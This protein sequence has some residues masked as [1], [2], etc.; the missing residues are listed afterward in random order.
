MKR[1]VK[2]SRIAALLV[3]CAAFLCA[4][5]LAAEEEPAPSPVPEEEPFV[6]EPA[7]L[8]PYG[9]DTANRSAFG[10]ADARDGVIYFQNYPY[11]TLCAI[12]AQGEIQVL[13]E[14]CHGMINASDDA[15][16]YIGDEE[17]GIFR[18]DYETGAVA[19]LWDGT[20]DNMVTT[21]NYVFFFAENTLY[22]MEK[23][24]SNRIPVMEDLRW[25]YL[26]VV[27][28]TVYVSRRIDDDPYCANAYS[29][30][31]IDV[32]VPDAIT[33]AKEAM[34]SPVQHLGDRILC[35]NLNGLYLLEA[36]GDGRTVVLEED[37]V[38]NVR[39]AAN[40]NAVFC[41]WLLEDNYTQMRI[42]DIGTGRMSEPFP[43][44]NAA[45]Y[46]MDSKAYTVNTGDRFQ[47]EQVVPEPGYQHTEWLVGEGYRGAA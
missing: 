24:G 43:V 14:D 45:I 22:R 10:M 38:S 16:Y 36:E 20:A 41:V 25:S 31:A 23:D 18:F 5:N 40:G 33:V 44:H 11:E 37:D 21:K 26:D 4:C 1:V 8:A 9:A 15:L 13:A 46:F 2:R 34:P 35:R 27:G 3:L 12:D 42:Y 47:L 32:N 6:W 19:K 28:E 7:D 17:K 39:A 29:L 30:F